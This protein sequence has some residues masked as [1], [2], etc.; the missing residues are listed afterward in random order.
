MKSLKFLSL[1]M[2]KIPKSENATTSKLPTPEELFH[3]NI[4]PEIRRK[5]DDYDERQNDQVEAII[6]YDIQFQ[7]MT[8]DELLAT[9]GQ[10]VLFEKKANTLI[11]VTQY[12]R[13][14]YNFFK[15]IAPILGYRV[16]IV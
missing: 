5:L 12:W 15:F 9:H 16:K 11:A 2:K 14:K 13:G 4:V 8:F 10:M 1:E 7:K 6:E 3:S